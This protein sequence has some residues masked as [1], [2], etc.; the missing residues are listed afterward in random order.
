MLTAITAGLKSSTRMPEYPR[1][2]RRALYQLRP[3]SQFAEFMGCNCATTPRRS[4]IGVD[5]QDFI[6]SSA[7]PLHGTHPD[8]GH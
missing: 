5:Y 3:M 1:F 4:F 8:E 6:A 7:C 2:V